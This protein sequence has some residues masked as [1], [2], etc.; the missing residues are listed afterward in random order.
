MRGSYRLT[1]AEKIKYTKLVETILEKLS[2]DKRISIDISDE[3]IAPCHVDEILGSLEWERDEME[4]NGWQC[5]C[6]AYYSHTDYE[7]TIVMYYEAFTFHLE[8]HRGD[9]DDK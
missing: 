5:D 7:Y 2:E 3:D 6:W 9:I 1:E 8:L 4:H